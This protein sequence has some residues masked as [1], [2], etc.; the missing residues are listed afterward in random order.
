MLTALCAARLHRQATLNGLPSEPICIRLS[1]R[2]I[3]STSENSGI[4]QYIH[5]CSTWRSGAGRIMQPVA[6][7]MPSHGNNV[8]WILANAWLRGNV[9]S[10]RG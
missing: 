10:Y 9:P 6:H 2:K 1:F 3:A 5:N 7:K 4:Y 8:N